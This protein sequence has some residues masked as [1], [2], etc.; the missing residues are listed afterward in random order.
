MGLEDVDEAR[1]RRRRG[2][3]A[4]DAGALCEIL[5]GER[6]AHAVDAAAHWCRGGRGLRTQIVVARSDLV[7]ER[8]AQ[9]VDA[10][11]HWCRGGRGLRTQNVVARRRRRRGRRAQD[12]EA[13][14]VDR[15]GRG[16]AEFVARILDCGGAELTALLLGRCLA[17]LTA[18]L[19]GRCL[20]ELTA[21][22]RLRFREGAQVVIGD[23]GSAGDVRERVGC[24]L[25]VCGCEAPR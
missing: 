15:R 10:A 17:E 5:V 11:A 16:G 19:L 24:V 22:R 14:G 4:E 23:V 13:S 1:E 25:R 20:T 21:R 2:R 8:A 6:A 18:L 12:A 7:G 9:G 3:C